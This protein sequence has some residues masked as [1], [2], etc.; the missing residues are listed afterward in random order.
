M[1]KKQKENTVTA[2]NTNRVIIPCP[3]GKYL[4]VDRVELPKFYINGVEFNEY[5]MR[6]LQVEVCK[7]TV[8]H[9]LLNS[10]DVLDAYGNKFIFRKD[11]C[12][13]NTP[14]GYGVMSSFTMEMIKTRK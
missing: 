5:D 12:L 4:V 13:V 3:E 14:H 2:V 7:G 11:G 1:K 9:E 6:K 8:S 10:I